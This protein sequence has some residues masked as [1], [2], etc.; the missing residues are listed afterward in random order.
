MMHQHLRM[1]TFG[2]FITMLGL[3]VGLTGCGALSEDGRSLRPQDFAAGENDVAPAA[4]TSSNGDATTSTLPATAPASSAELP[5]GNPAQTTAPAN[6]PTAAG[7]LLQ[8]SMQGN[9]ADEAADEAAVKQ[10]LENLPKAEFTP[11]PQ[12]QGPVRT[13]AIDGMIGQVSGQAIYAN[14]VLEPLHEQFT[15]LG[16]TLSP[17]AFRQE[18]A[19][20]IQAMLEEIVFN[21]LIL[22]EAERDLSEEEQMGLTIMLRQQREQLVRKYGAGSRNVAD[23]TL[24][25]REGKSLDQKLQEYRQQLLIQRY[26][27][28]KLFPRINIAR[29]DIERYYNDNLDEFQPKPTRQVRLIRAASPAAGDAIGQ[30]L[31]Q[32]TGFA[33][34]ARS[35]HNDYRREQSG[36][37]AEKVA[38]DEIFGINELN[39]A[40]L[41]LKAGE[42]SE[43]IKVDSAMYWVMV[44]TLEQGQAVSLRE[45]QTQIEERLRR[46]RFQQLLASYRNSLFARGSYHSIPQMAEALLEIAVNRYARPT[47]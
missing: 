27:Q 22:G 38:G 31:A 3:S 30:A 47:G 11:A 7:T 29:K 41:K 19:K 5:S 18:A 8:G 45:A 43:Q 37:F 14:R 10:F 6:P 1:G 46:Q 39:D 33:E 36:L 9:A 32:G 13:L 34:V 24:R 4:A 15:R 20:P 12:A 28:L 21:H 17:K 40:V 23:E 35:L 2:L 44:E 16:Q 26:M 25:Q 42:H